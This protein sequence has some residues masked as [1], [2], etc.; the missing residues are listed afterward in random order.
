[1][2][3][4]E[5]GWSSPP[6]NKWG[7]YW[8]IYLV[9][10]I[11]L[12]LIPLTFSGRVISKSVGTFVREPHRGQEILPKAGGN[13]EIFQF[14][15][16]RTE[17][18]HNV[19]KCNRLN[20]SWSGSW[21]LRQEVFQCLNVKTKKCPSSRWDSTNYTPATVSCLHQIMRDQIFQCSLMSKL[22]SV[23]PAPRASMR[24][25]QLHPP[26]HSVSKSCATKY[27]KYS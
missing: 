24:F 4:G 7:S 14:Y 26:L 9:Y 1:M 21:L 18:S 11:F 22:R 6:T 3:A 23:L 17:L 10:F 25:W 15:I 27:F 12:K 2:A 13:D 5:L 19:A 20:Q 16:S 8:S